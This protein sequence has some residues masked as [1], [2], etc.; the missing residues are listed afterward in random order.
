MNQTKTKEEILKEFREKVW[1][2]C[3]SRQ[4]KKD[5]EYNCQQGFDKAQQN[6]FIGN[7]L[8]IENF[9]LSKIDKALT[10]QQ[11]EIIEMIEGIMDKHN[12]DIEYLEKFT[13]LK[14]NWREE[15]EEFIKERIKLN[16]SRYNH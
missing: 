9:W 14:R 12:F 5:F 8:M 13:K 1:K 10:T 3:W 6:I 16:S 4:T 11:E 2:K 15:R 7:F